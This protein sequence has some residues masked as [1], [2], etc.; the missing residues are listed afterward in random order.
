M[1]VEGL[2]VKELDFHMRCFCAKNLYQGR[3]FTQLELFTIKNYPGLGVYFCD[4][5]RVCLVNVKPWLY[6]PT[7]TPKENQY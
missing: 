2:D 7:P 6:T 3:K 1:R 5:M 4:Y